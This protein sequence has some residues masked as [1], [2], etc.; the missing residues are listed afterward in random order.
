[1]RELQ[2]TFSHDSFNL[3][4]I[5]LCSREKELLNIVDEFGE[6]SEDGALALN[7][8]AYLHIFKEKIKDKACDVFDESVFDVSDETFKF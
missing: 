8:L 4:W 5:S 3:L 2:L 7:D 6:D 1:M